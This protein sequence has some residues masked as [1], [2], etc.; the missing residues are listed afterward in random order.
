VFRA[1]KRDP[2]GPPT[3]AF[4]ERQH[5]AGM[6]LLL[7]FGSTGTRE[8]GVIPL[9]ELAAANL[10]LSLGVCEGRAVIDLFL[11]FC[12]F[13]VC[14]FPPRLFLVWASD[15]HGTGLFMGRPSLLGMPVVEQKETI[16]NA[17]WAAR[18]SRDERIALSG[19]GWVRSV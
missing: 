6:L 15:T 13:A 10:H 7:G 8:K 1:K 9:E 14:V 2:C 11:R 4:T 3:P 16:E 5:V 12:V 19:A 17:V 18:R